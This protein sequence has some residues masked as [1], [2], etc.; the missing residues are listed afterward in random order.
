MQ[1]KSA[2]PQWKNKTCILKTGKAQKQPY[3]LSAAEGNTNT[4]SEVDGCVFISV[5]LIFPLCLH[6]LCTR[7][8]AL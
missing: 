5:C 1:R 3:S 4:E 2:H 7:R 6:M 8:I